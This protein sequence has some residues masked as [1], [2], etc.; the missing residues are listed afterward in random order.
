M[1]STRRLIAAACAALT[2][3]LGV[4]VAAAQQFYAEPMSGMAGQ[5]PNTPA[6]PGFADIKA[7]LGLGARLAQNCVTCHQTVKHDV[8]GI[9]PISGFTPAIFEKEMVAFRTK[10]RD[11]HIMQA[12]AAPL[13]D[14]DIA[15]VATYFSKLP[16]VH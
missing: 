1:T 9:P 6:P 12:V 2:V 11:N 14:E 8:V 7:D 16:S 15:A 5:S 4:G 10:Q 13:S 3:S